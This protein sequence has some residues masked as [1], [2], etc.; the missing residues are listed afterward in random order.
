[1]NKGMKLKTDDVVYY[2]TKHGDNRTVLISLSSGQSIEEYERDNNCIVT[3]IERPQT[4]YEVK[5]V[6]DEKEKDYLGKV[7]E[8]F[9]NGVKC[10]VKKRMCDHSHTLEFIDIILYSSVTYDNEDKIPLPYFKKGK[11]YKGMKLDKEYT[12]KELG[13]D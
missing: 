9:K 12:L 3:K 4:I 5:E 2:K 11:M 1:M 8:P 13:L 10:I 7:I 6:L